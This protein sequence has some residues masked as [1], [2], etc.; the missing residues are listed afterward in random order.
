M[1]L[2]DTEVITITGEK[3]TLSDY[4]GK[5][6]LIVN[7]ATACGLTPQF[8][9][10]E[11]LH[12][13]FKDRGFAVLGFPCNQFAGQEPLDE[14]GIEA[15]CKRNYGVTFPLFSKIEVNG[16]GAHPLFRKL[17]REAP[18]FAGIGAIKWNFTKFL[19]NGQGEVIERFAP[20][21]KP[22]ALVEKIEAAISGKVA[23]GSWL[24]SPP[25]VSVGANLARLALGLALLFAGTAHLSFQRSEFLAQV[26]RW[27]P[28][29][30]DFVVLASGVVEL[31]LGASL[32]V[33][34][35]QRVLVGLAVAAFFVAIFPGN[36]S[37]YL[38][39][40]S[41]FGLD[42]DQARFIRLFFQPVL[43]AWALWSTGAGK[44]LGGLLRQPKLQPLH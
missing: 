25:K 11:A 24:T 20:T 3:K 9:G 38:N 43:V 4:A 39:G 7:T 19:V 17:K 29:D 35:R 5:T 41:A 33:L 23:K 2:H 26:P 28:L 1:K 6:L 31:L 15:A 21:D 34:A 12:Q 18:G 37:Q 32:V 44:A 36:L 13:R 42:T 14:Q 22:A 27:V 8:E 40:I 10:L 16:S 30:A